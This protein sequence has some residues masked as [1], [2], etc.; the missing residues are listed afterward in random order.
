M[1]CAILA[2]CGCGRLD[3][4]VQQTRFEFAKLD[5]M[6]DSTNE[7]LFVF[8]DSPE[9]MTNVTTLE[10]AADI[11]GGLGWEFVQK[12]DDGAHEVYYMR[13]RASLD[14]TNAWKL[15]LIPDLPPMR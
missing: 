7:T 9:I 5:W 2:L 1:L 15:F 3:S 14:E 8:T 11:A 13:R 4:R 6:H 12:S 10:A